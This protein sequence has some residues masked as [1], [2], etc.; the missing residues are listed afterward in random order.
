MRLRRGLA[1]LP[2]IGVSLLP[3]LMCPACWPAYAGIVSSLGLGLLI[4]E[5]YLLLL[6]VAFLAVSTATLGFRAER[7][8]GYGPFCMGAI[9]A[10]AIVVCKF[11]FDSERATYAG[12]TL[13]FVASLW[14]S[15]PRRADSAPC[16]AR[17]PAGVGFSQR[18]ASGEAIHETQN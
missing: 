8:H 16:S 14:N 5:K 9:A 17:I 10:A 7:R 3:K 2:G 1:V 12:V 11:Y 18:T 13:L 6:T 4:S 15:W